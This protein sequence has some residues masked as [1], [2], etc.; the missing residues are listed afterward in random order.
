M[1]V[2]GSS[3]P[4]TARDLEKIGSYVKTRFPEWLAEYGGGPANR[5]YEAE[6]RERIV[7]VEEE[8]K[9]Q[10][11]LMKQGFDYMEKRFEQIDKRLEQIDSRPDRFEDRMNDFVRW[12]RNFMIWSFGFSASLAGIV[13]GVLKFT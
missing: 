7:R 12:L 5:A 13:I 3:M 2:R 11:E 8:L 10:R 4:L 9:N 1:P 6:F